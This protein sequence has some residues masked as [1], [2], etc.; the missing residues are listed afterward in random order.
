MRAHRTYVCEKHIF[1]ERPQAYYSQHGR[2][3]YIQIFESAWN[4]VKH[5]AC[6][7]SETLNQK[8]VP[9]EY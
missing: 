1:I 5:F 2:Y 8:K 4:G 7:S 6:N 9:D 3:F